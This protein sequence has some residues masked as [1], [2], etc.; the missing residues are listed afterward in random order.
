MTTS[1]ELFQ[2]VCNQRVARR[3]RS[4]NSSFSNLVPAKITD[5]HQIHSPP[6]SAS[7]PSRLPLGRVLVRAT[8]FNS[9]SPNP[10]F[11][12]Q[13]GVNASCRLARLVGRILRVQVVP[14]LRPT[15]SVKCQMSLTRQIQV[16]AAVVARLLIGACRV[17]TEQSG[18]RFTAAL[19]R[20]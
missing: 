4:R 3:K 18:N 14:T 7:D 11:G 6:W 13:E 2:S 8:R 9:F 12:F 20:S 10:S 19:A 17:P 1:S 15:E 16:V 5:D